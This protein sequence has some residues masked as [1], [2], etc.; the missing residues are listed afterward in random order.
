MATSTYV[1]ARATRAGESIIRLGNSSRKL[2][3]TALA[4]AMLFVAALAFAATNNQVTRIAEGTKAKCK[5]SILSRNGE[6]IRIR[7]SKPG[8]VVIVDVTEATKIQREK[9]KVLFFRREDM[10]ITAMVPGLTIEVEGLGNS[11]GQLEAQK[12]RFTPDEFAIQVAEERQL[13]VNAVAAGM[14][15]SAANQAQSTADQAQGT[16]ND[17]SEQAQNSGIAAALDAQA[18]AML[19]QR[20]SDL[21]DY[22]VAAENDVYFEEDS[23]VLKE[24]AKPALAELARLAKSLDGY[25]IEVSGYAAHP[26]NKKIDFQKLSEERAEVVARYLFE[27]QNIPV[28]RILMPV[29][30]GTTHAMYSNADAVGREANRRVDVKVLVNNGQGTGF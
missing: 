26:A 17:A 28:R 1:Q 13:Q 11:A 3:L 6:L 14:A 16:A 23:A 21:D 15:Q 10:D 30:Y 2:V 12:I 22:T 5:G 8:S 29:G 18:I 4:T 9:S 24:E 27:G 25:M 7:G 20:V 19:N